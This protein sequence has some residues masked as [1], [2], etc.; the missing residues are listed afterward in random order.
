MI[1]DGREKAVIV[2]LTVSSSGVFHD[3]GYLAAFRV[4]RQCSVCESAALR[5]GHGVPPL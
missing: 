3:E 4:P 1:V 2:K 5:L